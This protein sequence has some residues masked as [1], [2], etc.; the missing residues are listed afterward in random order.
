MRY[1]AIVLVLGIFACSAPTPPLGPQ[2][3]VRVSPKRSTIV[4]GQSMP[5]SAATIDMAGDSVGAATVTW[6]S[7]TA[8]VASVSDSGVASGLAPGVATIVATASDG[9]HDSAVITV[10]AGLCG[11][12]DHK[13]QL[14]GTATF[15][16]T[17]NATLDSVTY[18]ANDA[19]T[20]EFTVDSQ[21]GTA[22]NHKIWLGSATGN[23][24]EQESETDL[25]TGQVRTATGSGP[26]I[27]SDINLSHAMVTIDLSACT[28]TLEG[29]PYVDVTESP[30]PGDLGPSWIG[31]F[32]TQSTPFDT[33]TR[34]Q[35]LA[36]HSSIWL[37]GNYNSGA[38]GWYVPLGFS[39]DY[40]SNGAPDDGSA[41]SVTVTYSVARGP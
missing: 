14:H 1:V 25:R 36:T 33:V 37:G 41:G 28:Y 11:G 2:D 34:T 39:T 21:G 6:K 10:V 35:P 15:T 8:S 20:M 4:V 5:L 27:V 31:W 19:A 40:F 9:A 18:V 30:D 24:S 22:N 32:R 17:Y 16:Y 26:L 7:F 13:A 23:G 3:H 12:V 29:V 38:G